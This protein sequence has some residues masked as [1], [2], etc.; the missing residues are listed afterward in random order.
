MAI[1]TGGKVIEG[2]RQR[3]ANPTAEGEASG[4]GLIVARAS[5]SF[6]ADGGAVGNI[7]LLPAATIPAGAVILGG[8]IDVTTP[9]TSGGAATIA[10]QVEGAADL[11]A[12]L[13]VASWTAGRKS[14]LPA[15]TGASSVKTTV[16]RNVVA[17]IAAAALTAGAFDVYLFYTLTA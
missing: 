4:Y 2:A 13:A 10:L 11:L 16:A 12:A 9:L 1:I 6:A 5:Y 7:N 15:F 3:A 8:F 14:I 17:V